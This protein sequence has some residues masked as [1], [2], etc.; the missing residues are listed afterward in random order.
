MG[1]LWLLDF[2]TWNFTKELLE[3]DHEMVI[4]L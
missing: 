3:N 4:F 1:V 2:L